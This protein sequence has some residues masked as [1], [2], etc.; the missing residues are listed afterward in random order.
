MVSPAL[1]PLSAGQAGDVAVIV[2]PRNPVTGLSS[3]DLR[4]I[5]AGEK[6]TWPGGVHVKLIVR[7]PGSHERIVL[8]RLLGMSES[9]YK[10]YWAAQVIRGEADSE[11]LTIPSFGMVKEAA[12]TFPGAIGLADAQD[13]KPGMLVKVLKVDGRMPGDDGYS[14]H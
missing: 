13:I 7:G 3:G 14:L 10:R 4:K 2:N 9:D 11:P 1:I 8:L 6:R 5:L 12:T